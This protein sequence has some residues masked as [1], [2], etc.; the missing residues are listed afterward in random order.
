MD[1]HLQ[2]TPGTLEPQGPQGLL[3]QSDVTSALAGVRLRS[4]RTAGLGE[5]DS[6]KIGLAKPR[7]SD[8]L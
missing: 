8:G 3:L 7:G 2:G 1:K 4:G 6:T 5:S